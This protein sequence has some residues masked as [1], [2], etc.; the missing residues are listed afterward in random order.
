MNKYYLLFFLAIFFLPLSCLEKKAENSN[1]DA[2]SNAVPASNAVSVSNGKIFG[3]FGNLSEKQGSPSLTIWNVSQNKAENGIFS[4]RKGQQ[5]AQ[6]MGIVVLGNRAPI[7]GVFAEVNGLLFE[8]EAGIET[9]TIPNNPKGGYR[10]VIPSSKLN[11]NINEVK[12]YII[13]K[14]KSGYYVAGDIAKIRI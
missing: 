8:G 11:E 7:I 10:V 13:P 14:D 5:H 6:I 9:P 4:L 2:V 3:E 12:F 1:L